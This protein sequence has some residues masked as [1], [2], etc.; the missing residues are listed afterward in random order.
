[1]PICKLNKPSSGLNIDC[2]SL[3]VG[4]P[5][6]PFLLQQNICLG[7]SL[8]LGSNMATKRPREEPSRGGKNHVA[9]LSTPVTGLKLGKEK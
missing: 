5:M 1:M 7:F 9:N 6:G 4:V 2:Y 8:S 3:T